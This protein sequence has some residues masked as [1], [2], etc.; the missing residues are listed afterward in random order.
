MADSTNP[1][2][3]VVAGA[4]AAQRV[5]DLFAAASPAI[6]YAMDFTTTTGL[7]WGYLGGGGPFS[8][9][10]I[11][12]GTV[13]LTASATNYIVASRSTGAVSASTATTNW[14]DTDN[15]ARVAQVVTGSSSITSYLDWRFRPGGTHAPGSSSSGGGGGAQC[16][17][18]A[19]SDETSSLTVGVAKATFRMPFG[20]VLSS[21]RASLTAAQSSGSTFTVD[22]NSNGSSILSTRITIDNGEKTSVTAAVP[23]VISNASLASDDEITIDIDQVGDGTATGLKVYLI[24]APA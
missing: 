5:N 10:A 24:G 21:V 9:A 14:N 18:I 11:S 22:I 20:F 6:V 19:C 3:Q 1:I 4:G 23:P 12:N 15:F 13:S 17:A 16:I 8:S 7:V 2:P